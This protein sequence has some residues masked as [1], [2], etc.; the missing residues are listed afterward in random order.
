VSL[1]FYRKNE[2][3]ISSRAQ[4]RPGRF[5][6]RSRRPGNYCYSMARNPTAYKAF[7]AMLRGDQPCAGTGGGCNVEK[8]WLRIS[9]FCSE[10]CRL[11][12]EMVKFVQ[13]IGNQL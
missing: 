6:R 5:P 1:P 8:G 4:E 12:C 11:R 10:D 9:L 7:L 3:G 2:E 13:R